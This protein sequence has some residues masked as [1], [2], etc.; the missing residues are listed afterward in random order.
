MELSTKTLMDYLA[1]GI[2]T[3]NFLIEF[4]EQKQGRSNLL[5]NQDPEKSPEKMMFALALPSDP[6]YC[7]TT[8]GIRNQGHT[9]MESLSFFLSETGWKHFHEREMVGLIR[10]YHLLENPPVQEPPTFK[11]DLLRAKLKT[12]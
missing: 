3:L 10:A 4:G 6:A 11:F 9:D 5:P 1:Q 12:A 2:N 7:L 8:S